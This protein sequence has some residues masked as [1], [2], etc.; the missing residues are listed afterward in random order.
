MLRRIIELDLFKEI[1][2]LLQE[3]ENLPL[4]DVLPSQVVLL[5]HNQAHL[6]NEGRGSIFQRGCLKEQVE[7]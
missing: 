3:E 4:E 2:L 6:G 5:G 1:F 7:V